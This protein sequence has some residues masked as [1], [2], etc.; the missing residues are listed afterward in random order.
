MTADET[1]LFSSAQ[2]VT[3]LLGQLAGAASMCWANLDGAGEFDTTTANQLVEDA[4]ARL[5]Q[6]TGA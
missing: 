1:N 2:N 3:Q 6:L 4:Q 5:R